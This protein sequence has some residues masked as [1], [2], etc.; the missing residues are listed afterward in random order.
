[1]DLDKLDKVA[2]L[3]RND[4]S[5]AAGAFAQQR[6]VLEQSTA[7]RAQLTN[8]KSEYEQRL[9]ALARDGMDARRLAD[10]RL[11]LGRLDEA[12][13]TLETEIGRQRQSL[14]ASRDALAEHSIK[15]SSVDELI[16][17]GRATLA[18][19]ERRAEQRQSDENSL[20]RFEP[21]DAG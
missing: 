13:A 11:F 20:R 12:L 19:E 18:Y 6:Q 21:P 4:E 2:L 1:M 8:F 17:R 3:A 5:R 15:R 9:Q 7:R 14:D 16:S 10:Y